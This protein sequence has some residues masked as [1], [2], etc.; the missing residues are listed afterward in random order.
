MSS[1][2]RALLTPL[3]ETRAL[4]AW[5]TVNAITVTCTIATPLLHAD[6][7]VSRL[8]LIVSPTSSGT[9]ATIVHTASQHFFDLCSNS[10]AVIA[11][12][13]VIDKREKL[14]LCNQHTSEHQIQ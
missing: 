3:P 12:Q 1:L 10:V 7:L 11:V 2:R 5:G 13:I 6:K 9:L 4:N 8:K 14:L